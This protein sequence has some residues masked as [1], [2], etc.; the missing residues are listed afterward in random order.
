MIVA[1]L[2]MAYWQ[3]GE[4]GAARKYLAEVIATMSTMPNTHAEWLQALAAE[5]RAL[6]DDQES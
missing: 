2:A 6:I 3:L 5:A 1:L 4:H